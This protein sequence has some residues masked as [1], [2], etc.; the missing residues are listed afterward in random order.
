M[1]LLHCRL[2]LQG[3][4]HEQILSPEAVL[5]GKARKT[6]KQQHAGRSVQEATGRASSSQ[7][8]SSSWFSFAYQS[9]KRN[10]CSIIQHAAE[11]EQKQNESENKK[12]LGD[13]VKYSNVIQVQPVSSV[14]TC[15]VRLSPSAALF[16]FSCLP[17]LCY[18]HPIPDTAGGFGKICNGGIWLHWL[19]NSSFRGW[20]EKENHIFH[21]WWIMWL[22]TAVTGVVLPQWRH[23]TNKIFVRGEVINPLFV[24]RNQEIGGVVEDMFSMRP[25]YK[26]LSLFWLTEV[27]NLIWKGDFLLLPYSHGW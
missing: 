8:A 12:L 19:L 9:L 27:V 24:E 15:G 17:R 1:P 7:S 10:L 4:S 2:P 23:C 21:W 13:V 25:D 11:L 22:F 5:E 18:C 20:I 14:N 16:L 26:S 3:V 6:R